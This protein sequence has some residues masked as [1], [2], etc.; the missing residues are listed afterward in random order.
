MTR[1]A[2]PLLVL[3]ALLC[4]PALAV[5][6]AREYV[7]LTGGVSLWEWEK[8]KAEPHDNWWANFV[9][10][11]RIRMADAS[12]AC[13]KPRAAHDVAA[14]LLVLAGIAGRPHTATNGSSHA[15][16]RAQEA[17]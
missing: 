2:L 1:F 5:D 13:G 4:R 8:Y 6:P 3:L 15:A 9:R 11:S 16:P 14:D 7:I 12:R 17:R 10:A